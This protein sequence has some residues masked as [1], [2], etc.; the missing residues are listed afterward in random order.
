MGAKSDV[1]VKLALVFFISLLSFAIGTF[2]GKK[3]SDNQHKLATLEPK[4]SHKEE[5]AVASVDGHEKKH[6]T[7]SDDEIKKLAE[8]FVADDSEEVAHTDENKEDNHATAETPHKTKET[9]Q[10]NT[11]APKAEVA[12]HPTE[13]AHQIIEGKTPH[14][15]AKA[16]PRHPTSIPKDVAQYSVG[17][18]TVQIASYAT[19]DE[20]KKQANELKE[21]GYSAFYVPA[22]VKGKSWYRVS[23]GLFATEDEAKNYRKE[24]SAKSKIEN[25]IIQKIVN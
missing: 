1:I 14:V 18:F 4:S 25:S 22:Q 19:E 24:F 16:Q 17:K 8:E 12:H 15:P 6:E 10:H 20:A 13:A 23:V 5:R 21:K 2:V 11:H 9:A 7:L 3:Y